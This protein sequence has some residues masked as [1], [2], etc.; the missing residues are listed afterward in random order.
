MKYSYNWIQKHI[1]ESLPSPEDLVRTITMS[2]FEVEETESVATDTVMDIKVLPD[3]SHDA[4]SHIGLAREIASVLGLTLN[5]NNTPNIDMVLPAPGVTIA[6]PSACPRFMAMR[7]ENIKVGESPK[8]LKESLESI[9][10]RS[11]NSVVDITN[12]VLYDLGK[13]M[14][15]FDADKVVGDL[16]VRF[17][18]LDE[19][20]VTL[21]GKDIELGASILIIADGAGPLS[22]AGVKGGNRAEV[23]NNT[24]NII[25]ES[26]NFNST[27]IRKTAQKVGIKTDAVRRFENGI[28]SELCASGLTQTAELVL[29]L[30]STQETLVSHITD[31]YPKPEKQYKVGVS[32]VEINSLLGSNLSDKQV[33]DILTCRGFNFKLVDS[34]EIVK[35]LAKNNL[36][37]PYKRGASVLYDAPDSF[38]CSSFTAYL[39]KEAGIAI[40]RIAV[41]QYV[42]T[43]A[44]E[45]EPE[46][47]DLI[48]TNTGMTITTKGS[49]YSKVLQR[50]IPESATRYESVEWMP[51]TKV[52]SGIDH[53]GLYVG[54]GMVVHATT[55]T[56]DVLLEKLSES[57]TFAKGYFVRY[58]VTKT[59]ERFVVTVPFE[60]LD[61]RIKEDLIDDISKI[62]GTQNLKTTED[63]SKKKSPQ[64]DKTLLSEDNVRN[65][66]QA[67][68]YSEI[69]TYTFRESGDIALINSVDPLKNK[70][71]TTLSTGIIESLEKG[72]YHSNF[73]G[74]ETVRVFE[75]GTVFSQSSETIKVAVGITSKNKKIKKAL[76]EELSEILESL[77]ANAENVKIS[78]Q[79]GMAFFEVSLIDTDPKTS[80]TNQSQDLSPTNTKYQTLS[81]YPYITRDVAFFVE[82][83]IN[84]MEMQQEIKNYAGDLCVRV[85]QFDRF[86]KEGEGK[87]SYGYRIVF[88][89][90]DRTLTDIEVGP[91][92]DSVY[93]LLKSKNFE[94]R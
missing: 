46:L 22:I 83:Q 3:R 53:V 89:A 4:L 90:F 70:L 47:G 62:I 61:L 30:C 24:K 25:I 86:Q 75:I 78:E 27:L 36:S 43:S 14:H 21:D 51:G 77:G 16:V 34:L 74:T 67:H 10:Q 88:Q 72:L 71:R 12:Y 42:Y 82:G 8:W 15:I 80:D 37:V 2:A 76:A 35:S 26:A 45:G 94:T 54:D 11:I 68:G 17:A 84:E 6:N 13:P 63:Y 58:V 33:G 85:Y 41:D 59:E 91:H 73:L 66:L 20:L 50:D 93:T 57:P 52:E 39:Y 18:T 87:V 81:N 65:T 92:T 9:G 64:K 48:F 5:K 44:R 1:T 60:R 40:P 19:K 69:I 55:R 38:D 28:T 79:D 23:N 32:T 56:G 49:N 29:D 31:I 7:V